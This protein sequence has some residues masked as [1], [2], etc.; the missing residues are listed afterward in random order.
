VGLAAGAQSVI[1]DCSFPQ[2]ARLG[3]FNQL[4]T[5]PGAAVV[6]T[7]RAARGG[8]DL[9]H[10]WKKV[11]TAAAEGDDAGPTDAADD[12]QVLASPCSL[13]QTAALLAN[14]NRSPGR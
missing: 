3:G 7:A 6:A 14:P 4:G 12:A 13:T 1:I 9:P 11:H 2:L 5:A 10:G 8:G